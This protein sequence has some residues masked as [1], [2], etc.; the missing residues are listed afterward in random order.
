MGLRFGLKPTNKTQ[1]EEGKEHFTKQKG[2]NQYETRDK[3]SQKQSRD[4]LN[5]QITKKKKKKTK[6]KQ[7]P[8]TM[9][10]TVFS[11]LILKNILHD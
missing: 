5:L 1:N 11:F 4:K 6:Q 9:K 7:G 10:L 2:H 8:V 3:T